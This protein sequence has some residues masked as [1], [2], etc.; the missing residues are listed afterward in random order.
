MDRTLTPSERRSEAARKANATRRANKAR[1]NEER[2]K[3]K[4]AYNDLAQEVQEAIETKLT[5]L[6]GRY[7]AA[8][9]EF[10]QEQQRKIWTVLRELVQTHGWDAMAGYLEGGAI[11]KYGDVDL[12]E[13][14]RSMKPLE[15]QKQRAPLPSV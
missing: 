11:T 1:E 7:H 13:A 14:V 2:R 4:L 10:V 6:E 12:L 5:E 15:E 8:Y 9:D 3:R